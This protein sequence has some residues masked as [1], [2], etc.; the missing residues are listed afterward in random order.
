MQGEEIYFSAYNGATWSTP[1]GITN[2]NL[3]D[4]AP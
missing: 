3:Q 1:T 2:D 4:F